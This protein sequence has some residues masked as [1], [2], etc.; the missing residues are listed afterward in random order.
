M[1][2][3]NQADARRGF[4][5]IAA[6]FF[7]GWLFLPS[8][9]AVRAPA[10]TASVTGFSF[11]ESPVDLSFLNVGDQPAGRHG[12][13]HVEGEHLAFA[14]GTE[15]RFWGTN[16]TGRALFQSDKS[17]VQR[18]SRRLARLGFN[19]VRIHHHDAP[20]V[21]PNIFGDG[22]ANSS[23]LLSE[24]ALT[25]LDWLIKCLEDEGIYVWLDL[26]DSRQLTASDQVEGFSEIE[27]K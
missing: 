24:E 19:L 6:L 18:Q 11:A 23:A 13:L 27:K 1:L 12:F 20:W 3:L 16:I 8:I 4:Y 5:G 10:Q 21:K 14:D 9:V 15:A 7:L 2:S 25:R 26:Y 22:R 17:D